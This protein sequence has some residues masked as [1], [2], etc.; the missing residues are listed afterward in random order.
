[1]L[2]DTPG[3]REMQFWDVEQ[4]LKKTFEEID[5]LAPSCR[6]KDCRHDAEPGCA[7]KAAVKDGRVAAARLESWLKLKSESDKRRKAMEK[8]H[9]KRTGPKR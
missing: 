3:M 8:A 1:M 9:Y 7:V 4:G 2:L 6:F 5:A